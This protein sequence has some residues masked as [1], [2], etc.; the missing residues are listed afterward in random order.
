[1][2][3]SRTGPVQVEGQGA[4]RARAEQGQGKVKYMKWTEYDQHHAIARACPG[5]MLG[6]EG[7]GQARIGWFQCQG[8][9]GGGQ[10]IAIATIGPGQGWI[11]DRTRQRAGPGRFQGKGRARKEPGQG[12][13][14]VSA[15]Y[16][17]CG[18]R[19]EQD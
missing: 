3:G 4:S 15:G 7:A 17:K 2:A 14:R 19:E 13:V 12:K 18:A 8:T 1:M 16:R 5:V 9:A 10:G 11:R 6:Q